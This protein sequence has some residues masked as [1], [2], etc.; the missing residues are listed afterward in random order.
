[1]IIALIKLFLC[2][3][4]LYIKIKKVISMKK[5]IATIHKI[6]ISSKKSIKI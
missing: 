3:G 1:M 2:L 5:E 6:L 4:I